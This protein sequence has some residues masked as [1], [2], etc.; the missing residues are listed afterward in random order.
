MP[1]EWAKTYS[2]IVGK[3]SGANSGYVRV[4]GSMQS[5]LAAPS[6]TVDADPKRWLDHTLLDVAQDRG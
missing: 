3:S 1:R 4:S 2:V 6:M 5:L